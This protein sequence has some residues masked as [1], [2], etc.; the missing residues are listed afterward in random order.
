MRDPEKIRVKRN[1]QLKVL[2]PTA[3]SIEHTDQVHL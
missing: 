2:V 1:V 3:K